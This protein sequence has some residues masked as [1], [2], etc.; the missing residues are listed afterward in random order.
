MPSNVYF[1]ADAEGIV[2]ALAPDRQ[3]SLG[4]IVM[5]ESPPQN[6]QTR[7]NGIDA[8]AFLPKPVWGFLESHLQCM[9]GLV[10][11]KSLP[12]AW[13]TLAWEQLNWRGNKLGGFL[14]VFRYAQPASE[15]HAP[16]GKTLCWDQW[17]DDTFKAVLSRP[18][19]VRRFKREQIEEDY[20][21]G[22]DLGHFDRLVL[23]AHGGENNDTILLD[24]QGH[25]WNVNLPA[26]LPFEVLIF[27][28]ASYDGNFH[29]L[30]VDCLK[31]GAKSVVCGH[32]QLNADL[33]RSALSAWLDSKTPAY[34][35]LPML[36]AAALPEQGGLHWLRYYGEV[37]IT[38]YDKYT[39]RFFLHPK[40]PN[41]VNE[42][43]WLIE[44]NG[45][46]RILFLQ[47]MKESATDYWPLT[48][49]WLLPLALYW[50]EKDWHALL[51]VLKK[52]FDALDVSCVELMPDRAYALAGVHR[53]RGCYGLAIAQLT[54][55]LQYS[56]LDPKKEVKLLGSLLND[57]ID[58]NLPAL[59]QRVLDRLDA[60]LDY[61]DD[62]QQA[63][64][65]LDRRARLALRRGD[66]ETAQHYLRDKRQQ[67]S[68]HSDHDVIRELA[69]LLFISAWFDYTDAKEFA[70][71]A[72][73]ALASAQDFS[74]GND[75][76]AYL[77][78][79]LAVWQWRQQ[80]DNDVIATFLPVCRE[81]MTKQDPGPFA[82]I[83]L[84]HHLASGVAK[85]VRP[86]IAG[87]EQGRYWLELATFQS[88][89][90]NAPEAMRTLK[91][92]Q[93]IRL[94]AVQTL[95]KQQLFG[96]DDWCTEATDR[97]RLENDKLLNVR[98]G[99]ADLA[100]FGLLPL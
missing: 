83:L 20:K 81:R 64:R 78:R 26:T 22:S 65:L 29:D 98:V 84:C 74:G 36:R 6:E 62:D 99:A 44:N 57:L 56:D 76:Y 47:A 18:G 1:W 34:E 13:H 79:A 67:Q 30:A 39:W 52:Q 75:D 85:N 53:R 38:D 63:F 31:H 25:P 32:G 9:G 77:L 4:S 58:L 40:R 14:L 59:G 96:W 43:S 12:S 24:K 48:Q 2:H 50:A 16:T 17:E 80:P 28:C 21:S 8:R 89:L 70:E 11:D 69:G 82:Y 94:E 71:E 5:P 72:I 46:A 10:L 33:M 23:L 92:F 42:L 51:P 86:A 3:V 100:N 49:F 60:C 88:L 15:W 54:E 27:A 35:T 68:I 45:H 61:V 37:P 93:D 95:A 97:S 90:G 55:G 73:K 91:K 41:P 66:G 19:I 87:L 7:P